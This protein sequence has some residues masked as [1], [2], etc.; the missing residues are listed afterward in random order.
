MKSL[1]FKKSLTFFLSLALFFGAN[2]IAADTED[3]YYGKI[4]R[5]SVRGK[6]V[7]VS[8]FVNATGCEKLPCKI[9]GYRWFADAK[10]LFILNFPDRFAPFVSRKRVLDPIRVNCVMKSDFEY[11]DCVF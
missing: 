3:I 5:G 1:I 9:M 10:V 4:N 6:R 2:M 7:S 8:G 11:V